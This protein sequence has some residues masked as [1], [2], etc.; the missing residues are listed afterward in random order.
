MLLDTFPRRNRKEEWLDETS[1]DTIGEFH[2]S[3]WIQTEFFTRWLEHFMKHTK[4]T[5]E[6]PV[7]LASN[8]HQSHTRNL[9]VIEKARDNHIMIVCLLPHSTGKCRR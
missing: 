3:G 1:S 5:Q 8:G 4:T 2:P 9:D 6:D 7:L